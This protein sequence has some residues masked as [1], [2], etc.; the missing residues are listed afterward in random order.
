MRCTKNS[1]TSGEHV[2]TIPSLRRDRY[3]NVGTMMAKIVRRSGLKPWPKLWH[4]LWA[5]RETELAQQYPMH[6]V[7]EWIGNS[8]AVAMKHYLRVTDADYLRATSTRT[9]ASKGAAESGA[10]DAENALQNA[11]QQVAAGSGNTSQ[12]TNKAL[13][14]QGFGQDLQVFS[15]DLTDCPVPPTGFEPVLPD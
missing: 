3:T 9:S 10:V 11:K 15:H 6:V 12:E 7:C 8:Q 5:T 14:N 13:A 4:N 2:I 1:R